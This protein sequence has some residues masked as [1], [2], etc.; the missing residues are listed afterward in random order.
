MITS[1]TV[2]TPENNWKVCQP[3]SNRSWIWLLKKLE[4]RELAAG[5]V[6]FVLKDAE[7]TEIEAVKN[8]KDGKI[9][10]Q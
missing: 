7:G 8:D 3:S 6:S 5:E 2:K 4:G 1:K 9:K 10:F